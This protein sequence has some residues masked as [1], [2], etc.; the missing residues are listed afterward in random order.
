MSVFRLQVLHTLGSIQ[1]NDA[2]EAHSV[3]LQFVNKMQ[4]LLPLLS[5]RCAA[6]NRKTKRQRWAG[7]GGRSGI[8]LCYE[9]SIFSLLCCIYHT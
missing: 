6:D 4:V 2:T 5:N 3:F 1:I 7:G 9:A 8:K